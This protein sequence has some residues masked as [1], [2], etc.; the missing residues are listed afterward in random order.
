M[1]PTGMTGNERTDPVALAVL[2]RPLSTF[3]SLVPYLVLAVLVVAVFAPVREFDFVNFDDNEYLIDNYRVQDGLTPSN[4]AWALTTRHFSNWH[5]LTWLSYLF[6]I[7][8]FGFAPGPMH[9]MNLAFHVLAT[10]LLYHVLVLATSAR[11][12]SLFVAFL[13]GIHPL[14]VESVAWIS[15]RKD[16]L[17]AVFWMLTLGAYVQYAGTGRRRHLWLSLVAFAC[18]L[19]AKPMLVTVPI[20]LFVLDYW[21]LNRIRSVPPMR[22]VAEKVPFF[23]LSLLSG[24]VTVIIQGDSGAIQGLDAVAPVSRL[25]NAI[26]STAGYLGMMMLPSNLSVYY[27]HPLGATPPLKI[28]IGLVCVCG[29]L[30]GAYLARRRAPWITAGILW[31]LVTLAPVIGIIQVGAQA[32]ADRYTYIPA[33]GVFIAVAWTAAALPVPGRLRIASAVASVLVFAFLARNQVLFWRDTETLFKHA[34]DV[35]PRNVLAYDVL[36]RHY[37]GKQRFA[38]AETQ[39]RTGLVLNPRYLEGQLMLGRA[40]AEQN[41]LEEALQPL[42]IQLLATPDHGTARYHYAR[43]LSLLGRFEDAT[44]AYQKL[45][46]LNPRNGLVRTEYAN[47][48]SRSGNIEAALPEYERAIRDDPAYSLAPFN[49][50][51]AL[52][53][54]GREADAAPHFAEAVRLDPSLATAAA[55]RSPVAEAAP[56]E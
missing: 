4:V 27:P 3:R 7:T 41:K 31:Y 42:A 56:P 43:T 6:D 46:R 18:G 53:L 47:M 29:L 20:I 36:G 33:I 17:S 10:L 55:Q 16:V 24:F 44:N 13:F 19:M 11:G 32:M 2:T 23:L 45:I 54:L 28:V 39:F 9:V 8:V 5:P 40:L 37:F 52:R 49:Y 12:P 14:H 48:L 34:L 25:T 35:T 30:A 1:N 50:G 15:E 21:P 38:E 22:L 26:V 51:L